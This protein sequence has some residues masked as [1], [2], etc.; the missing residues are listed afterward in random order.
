MAEMEEILLPRVYIYDCIYLSTKL[1]LVSA[2][3]S[4]TVPSKLDG[5]SDP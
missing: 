3:R 5:E 4:R 2:R 1:L